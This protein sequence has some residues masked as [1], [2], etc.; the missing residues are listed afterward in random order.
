MKFIIHMPIKKNQP[1]LVRVLWVYQT[2]AFFTSN[3]VN[4]LKQTFLQI[5]PYVAFRHR[6]RPSLIQRRLIDLSKVEKRLR[7]LA[8]CGLRIVKIL[9]HDWFVR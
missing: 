2:F 7:F 6:A 3:S 5:N 1:I 4:R 8:P 9:V